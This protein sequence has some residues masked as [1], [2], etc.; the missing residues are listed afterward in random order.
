MTTNVMYHARTKHVEIDIDFVCDIY[1]CTKGSW[2]EVRADYWSDSW[3][4]HE[5]IVS[6]QI[7]QAQEQA[8]SQSFA[9]QLSGTVQDQA[10]SAK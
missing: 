2:S 6:E 8:E 9:A 10:T 5:G 1:G 3:R 7:P 4:A